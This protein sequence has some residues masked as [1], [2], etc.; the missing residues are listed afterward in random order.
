MKLIT[1][2]GT[3]DTEKEGFVMVFNDDDDLNSFLA[4]IATV[5]VKTS[6]LRILALV[7][8]QLTTLQTAVLDVINGMDGICSNN[9]ITHET[10][11]EETIDALNKILKDK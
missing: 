3:F 9:S 5:P 4:Q 11:V 7:P 2:N 6:G 8:G 1:R 10:I